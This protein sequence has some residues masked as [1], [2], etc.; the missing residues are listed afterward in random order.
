[1]EFLSTFVKAFVHQHRFKGP[2]FWTKELLFCFTDIY[3]RDTKELFRNPAWP[4]VTMEDIDAICDS[5]PS[6]ATFLSAY[7]G[8]IREP[9]PPWTGPGL[10]PPS[11][12]PCFRQMALDPTH[13]RNT[14][15][16][17]LIC[18]DPQNDF[19]LPTGALSVPDAESAIPVINELLTYD[20]SAVF[21]TAD[22][23]PTEHCSFAANNPGTTIGKPF[24]RANGETQIAWPVHCVAESPGAAFHRGL[25]YPDGGTIV[26]HKGTDPMKEEYSGFAAILPLLPEYLASVVICGFA[27]DYCVAATAKE[28]IRNGFNTTVILKACRGVAP[29]TTAIAIVE[30]R[31]LG[32][33]VLA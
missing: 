14:T 5:L 3:E 1:M 15:L 22:W 10:P 2:S 16:P 29:D 13:V 33:V 6:L 18:V 17:V 9:P 21:F 8:P 12:R 27:T 24:V 23:H 28:A 11:S 31:A 4:T 30:M 7:V 20:W 19:V 26:V 32:I 25:V